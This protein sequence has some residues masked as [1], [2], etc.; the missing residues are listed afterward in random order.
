MPIAQDSRIVDRKKRRSLFL[1][2]IYSFFLSPA[3]SMSAVMIYAI[4]VKALFFLVL[5]EN[6]FHLLFTNKHKVC[7]QIMWFNIIRCDRK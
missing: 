3:L 6:I 1:Y 4:S 5:L 7:D 2:F